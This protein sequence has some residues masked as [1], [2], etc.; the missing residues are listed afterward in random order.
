MHQMK[1][2]EIDN[3]DLGCGLLLSV[4]FVATTAGAIFGQLDPW[5]PI[6]AFAAT[7]IWAVYIWLNVLKNRFFASDEFHDHKANLVTVTRDY[8]A[9]ASHSSEIYG[10]LRASIPGSSSGQHAHLA[11]TS[12]TSKYAYNRERHLSRYGDTQVHNCSLQ[13]V[14]NANAEPLKYLCKYFGFETSTRTIESLENYTTMIS[15]INEAQRNLA[16]REKTIETTINPPS[17]IRSFFRKQFN[18]ELG[19]NPSAVHISFPTYT[20]EYVSAGGNSSQ[21]TSITLD[22][23]VAETLMSYISQK[24]SYRNSAAGQRSLMTASLR[25]AIKTRD[26]F[27]CQMCDLSTRDEPHLLLEV[28]HIIPVSRGGLSTRSNLQTLCWKC[29]RSKSNKILP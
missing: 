8:N 14:K 25:T 19:I 11:T 28:D 21:Q 9:I 27:T 12:N 16:K 7:A 20:F 4:A 29:N 10:R 26:N 22:V 24:L 2:Q 17:Y 23:K 13:V 15:R 6:A 1:N 3:S 18:G 5:V